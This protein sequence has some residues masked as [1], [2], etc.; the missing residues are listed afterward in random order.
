MSNK[1]LARS[2]LAVPTVALF[3]AT[4][5]GTVGILGALFAGHL[6]LPLA[7]GAMVVLSFVAFTPMHDSAHRAVGR[8]P[9][10]NGLIG[11]VCATILLVP[12]G[13]F[14]HIH[15]THHRYTNDPERDPDLYSGT[16]ASWQLPFRWMTQDLYY[17]VRYV[18]AGRPAAELLEAAFTVVGLIALVTTLG[19]SFGWT[20]V[21]LGWVLPTRLAVTFLAF[22]FDYLPHHP[23]AVPA[24][25]DPYQATRVIDRPWLTPV[26]LFQN[27]HLIHHLYPAIPFYRYAKVWRAKRSELLAKG[28]RVT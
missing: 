23:H 13:A 21:L 5:I 9:W 20:P 26:L 12:Y 3:L 7:A 6:A 25:E 22:A 18:Q 17:Y 28:V 24:A 10:L 19:L 1:L 8:A 16:G 27:Y 15:L 2:P 11:R 14:R 4:G